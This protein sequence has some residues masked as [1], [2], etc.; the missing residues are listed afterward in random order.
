MK[1]NL[2]ISWQAQRT[3]GEHREQT[4]SNDA[5]DVLESVCNCANVQNFHMRLTVGRVEEETGGD[6]LIVSV[7]IRARASMIIGAILCY[8]KQRLRVGNA[9]LE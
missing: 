1:K 4:A 7:M 2:Y 9:E 5:R 6:Q 8:A 3:D